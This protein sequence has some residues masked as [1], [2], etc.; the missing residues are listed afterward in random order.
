MTSRTDRWSSEGSGSRY[1]KEIIQRIRELSVAAM[2][3]EKLYGRYKMIRCPFHDDSTPSFKLNDDNS[4]YCFGCE[5]K[6]RNFI[7]YL[8]LKGY[9]FKDIYEEFKNDV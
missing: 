8:L 9:K 3:G 2:I 6:G 5:A 4:F 7:D 1:D